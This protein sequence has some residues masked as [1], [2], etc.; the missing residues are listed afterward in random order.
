MRHGSDRRCCCHDRQLTVYL[1]SLLRST[2]KARLTQEKAIEANRTTTIMPP[3][4]PPNDISLAFAHDG[5][6]DDNDDAAV[7]NDV[8][9]LV[10][11]P[12]YNTVTTVVNPYAKKPPPAASHEDPKPSADRLVVDARSGNSFVVPGVVDGSSSVNDI[13]LFLRQ[14]PTIFKETSFVNRVR[15]LNFANTSHLDTTQRHIHRIFECLK[16]HPQLQFL[17]DSIPDPEAIDKIIPR[18]Y[19]LVRGVPT[20][21]RME[22]LNSVMCFFGE[23]LFLKSYD[24]MDISILPPDERA[25]VSKGNEESDRYC[26]QGTTN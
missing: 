18:L 5:D 24:G 9:E 8:L 22:V 13:A 1:I 19:L 14:T 26:L 4:V 3:I 6:D 11:P 16:C 17:A 10:D 2:K 7:Q 23:S 15:S 21:A 25:K 20:E 12:P